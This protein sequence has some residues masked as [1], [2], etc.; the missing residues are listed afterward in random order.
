MT[1]R[2]GLMWTVAGLFALF[3]AAQFVPVTRTNPP[4]DSDIPAPADVKAVLRR[5]C[6][7]CHSNETVWPWYSYV[8]PVSWVVADDVNS[9]RRHV[10]F[11]T[12]N[13]VR[14][15][16]IPNEMRSIWR[17]VD[18][19]EMPLWYY[20]PMHPSARLSDADKALLRAWTE[21]R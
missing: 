5:A 18:S 1:R 15:D 9:G 7:D 17:H 20:L 6:Y 21:S 3:L 11:S 8:A 14:P 16:R 13:Q 10:N 12:W 4:V 2:R 19:G